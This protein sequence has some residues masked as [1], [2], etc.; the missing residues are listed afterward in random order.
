MTAR[1]GAQA[2]TLPLVVQVLAKVAMQVATREAAAEARMGAPAA[3]MTIA[4]REVP[5]FQGKT[6]RGVFETASSLG[7]EVEYAGNGIA[8]TQ[9]PAPGALLGPGERIRIQ[10]AR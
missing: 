3:T 10:F 1:V 5:N 2:S 6:M 7:F 9:F 8:R 4:G